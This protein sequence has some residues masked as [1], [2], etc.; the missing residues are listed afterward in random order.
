VAESEPV[1]VPV[2]LGEVRVGDTVRTMA[3]TIPASSRYVDTTGAV[4]AIRNGSIAV[5]TGS[6]TVLFMPDQLER[7]E[8]PE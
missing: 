8:R 6:D 3:G 4:V 5:K 1:W 7:Q 2:F